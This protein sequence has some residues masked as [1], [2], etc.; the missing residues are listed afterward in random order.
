MTDQRHDPRYLAHDDA[1]WCTCSCGWTSL[2]YRTQ[3]TAQLAHER[4]LLQPR[5]DQR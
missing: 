2:T 4:H 5:K 1:R 3:I